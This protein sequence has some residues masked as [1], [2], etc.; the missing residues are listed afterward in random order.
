[1]LDLIGQLVH[2]LECPFNG[3]HRAQGKPFGFSLSG[4]QNLQ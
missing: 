3:K 4:Q 1:L 2:K